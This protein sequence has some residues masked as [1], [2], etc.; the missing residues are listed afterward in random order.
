MGLRP[1]VQRA[2]QAVHD[3]PLIQLYLAVAVLAMEL[4]VAIHQHF[5]DRLHLPE[6]FIAI[7]GSYPA[8]LHFA[9][10]GL[11]PLQVT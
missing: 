2:G 7:S 6:R 11:R 1:C 3:E 4:C 5:G 8:M 10:E 9:L